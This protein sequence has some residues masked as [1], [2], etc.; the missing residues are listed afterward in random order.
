MKSFA[1]DEMCAQYLSGK[2]YDPCLMRR[3]ISASVFGPPT[4]YFLMFR[5]TDWK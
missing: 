1:A 4:V 5:A 2:R 3:F